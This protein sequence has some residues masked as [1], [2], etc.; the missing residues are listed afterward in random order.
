M[1][2]AF[3]GRDAA[4]GALRRAQLRAAFERALDLARERGAEAI[5][6]AGDLYEDQRAG[7]DTAAYLRR[8]LGELAPVRVFLS[9]GNHDPCAPGSVYR[10]MEP[11][12]DNIAVFDERNFRAVK[13]ADGVTLWGMGQISAL[14]RARALTGLT[15]TG[16]GTHLLL[17]HGSDENSIR[18]GK[19]MIAPFNDAEV[20]GAG[21]A[22]AMVG[23]FHGKSRGAHHAYPGS[24]EPLNSAQDGEHTASIV[25]VDRGRVDVSFEPINR[26]R[27]I[28]D[29][30]DVAQ[31]GDSA[32]L[33]HAVRA[34]AESAV[35]E[36]G[37]V[38]CRIRLIGAAPA[39]LDADLQ[40]L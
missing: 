2:T 10:Q 9:P 6:I 36:P 25:T 15:C 5:C 11:L 17:F 13:L 22:H 3:A 32:A 34:K 20:A 28:D 31:F 8:T 27:Y 35:T 38:F 37:A 33:L 12:P 14:D 24:P 26:T 4:F 29:E 30:L 23:H 16:D 18:P 19:E 40:P 21:A 7:P 39:S 1:E